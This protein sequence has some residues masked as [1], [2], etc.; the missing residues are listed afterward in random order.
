MKFYY[1]TNVFDLR[2]FE[3]ST[4]IHYVSSFFLNERNITISLLMIHLKCTVVHYA[5]LNSSSI[6]K[7]YLRAIEYAISFF[8]RFLIYNYF[9]EA[10][11][12]NLMKKL[13][14][15]STNIQNPFQDVVHYRILKAH[16]QV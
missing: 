3:I 14:I 13:S 16:Y 10:F 11:A 4:E 8:F 12:K 1:V 6:N 2:T 5:N 9:N 15:F 7:P